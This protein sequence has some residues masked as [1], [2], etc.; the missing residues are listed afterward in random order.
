MGFKTGIIGLP[1]VG[2]STLFNLII[3][4]IK[5]DAGSI[6]INSEIVNEYPIYIRAQKFHL[7]VVPQ[8]GGFFTDLTVYENLKAISEIT[9]KNKHQREEKINLSIS[10]FELDNIR[11]VK[12]VSA[13]REG[14]LGYSG[15]APSFFLK[16]QTIQN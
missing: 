10:K 15:T 6:Y 4:L 14:L 13:N 5:P 3:G 9:I 8:Q 12:M 2:K 11:D 16:F 7:G 1:N